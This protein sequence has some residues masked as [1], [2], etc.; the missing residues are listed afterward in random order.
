MPS[1]TAVHR[2]DESARATAADIHA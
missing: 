2:I 1:A